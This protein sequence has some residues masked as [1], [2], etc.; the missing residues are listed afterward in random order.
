M[1]STASVLK[2]VEAVREIIGEASRM[3]P[4]KIMD[5]LDEMAISFIRHSPFL[6]LGTTGEDGMPEI[7]PKG[8]EAGF[9]AV[10]DANT[11]L[12]PERRG[13]RLIFSLQNILATETVAAIFMVPGTQET[14]RVQGRA[15]LSADPE[16]CGR[17]MSR[18]RPALLVTRVT[19]ERCYF[20]CAK[21][22]KRARLW[23]PDS[24]PPRQQ[25]SFGRQAADRLGVDDEVAKQIDEAVE[26]DYRT[27]L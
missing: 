22:F 23:D 5:S 10:E 1:S 17:F 18:S 12:I 15:E 27:N 3:T 6:V 8:D 11:L 19:V 16:L 26:E 4:L 25:I 21:A 13:N 2:S 14:L 7:S 9:V 24:W 20:H